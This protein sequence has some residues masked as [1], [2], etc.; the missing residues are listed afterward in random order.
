VP[1]FGSAED[2]ADNFATYIILQFGK[3]QARRL[4]L[5]DAWAWRAYLGDFKRNP[6][7][8]LRLAAFAS[9]HGL[10]QERYYNL[11]CLAIGAQ[12][13]VF[14]DLEAY[15]PTTRFPHCVFEYRRVA[16][17]FDKAIGPYIDRE[18]AKQILD[19]DWL[20]TLKSKPAAQK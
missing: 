8:P 1:I 18:M 17:A 10:P 6:V 19:A 15:L 7:V 3:N 5:G 12:R 16:H 14:A 13:E 4:I 20:E 11:L 2:A 9:D